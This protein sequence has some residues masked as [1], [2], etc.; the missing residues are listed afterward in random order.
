MAFR[1]SS[2]SLC[3]V[4]LESMCIVYKKDA[5][6]F[7]GSVYNACLK[8]QKRSPMGVGLLHECAGAKQ[9]TASRGHRVDQ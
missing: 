5:P 6:D 2:G 1:R 8:Q 3:A 9:L 4:P 7:T